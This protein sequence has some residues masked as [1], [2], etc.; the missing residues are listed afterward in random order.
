MY[1]PVL[2]QVR[3][4]QI[5]QTEESLPHIASLDKFFKAIIS[6]YENN[7]KAMDMNWSNQKANPA[8]EN[9]RIFDNVKDI[10]LELR[11]IG[12][13]GMFVSSIEKRGKHT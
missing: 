11:K 8:L 2:S 7:R 3:I 6:D 10:V 4:C 5:L 13:E 1:T 9:C 12:I